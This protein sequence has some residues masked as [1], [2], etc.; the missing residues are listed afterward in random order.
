MNRRT[1]LL[2]ALAASVLILGLILEPLAS[3]RLT[4]WLGNPPRSQ[5]SPMELLVSLRSAARGSD[6]TRLQTLYLASTQVRIV[7][8]ELAARE[9]SLAESELR[10]EVLARLGSVAR[11]EAETLERSQLDLD[12]VLRRK[13]LSRLPLDYRRGAFQVPGVE[14]RPSGNLSSTEVDLGPGI[15][16]LWLARTD[17]RWE[18]VPG[19]YRPD[20]DLAGI[21][22]ALERLTAA[23]ARLAADYRRIAEQLRRGGPEPAERYREM[24]LAAILQFLSHASGPV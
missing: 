20:Q 23:T 5:A 19:A 21:P 24:L 9:L 16:P 18:L 3:D 2:L 15:A 6:P 4:A 8:L 10:R 17:S 7:E 11:E 14:L 22:A 13:D 12:S 1:A